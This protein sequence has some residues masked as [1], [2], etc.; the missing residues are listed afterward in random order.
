[1]DTLSKT[2]TYAINVL[3]HVHLVLAVVHHHV[4]HALMELS[5]KLLEQLM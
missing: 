1:M 3:L 4:L 2:Q 5:F